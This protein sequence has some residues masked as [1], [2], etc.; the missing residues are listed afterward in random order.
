MPVH[1]PPP[2]PPS[3][4]PSLNATQQASRPDEYS[5]AQTYIE[6]WKMTNGGKNKRRN[7]E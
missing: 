6:S 7:Q 2:P 5:N 1:A 3:Q 4:K